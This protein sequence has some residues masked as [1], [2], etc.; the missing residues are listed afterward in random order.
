MRVS[1]ALVAISLVV[2]AL[3]VRSAAQTVTPVPF[4]TGDVLVTFKPGVN[5]NA[6][7]DAHRVVGATTLVEIPR[8]R[9]HRVRV[10]AG[11]E[12]AAIAR[13]RRNPNVLYAEPNF[14]RRISTPERPCSRL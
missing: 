13:Y 5:A 4:V 2:G 7:A 12:S 6:R 11:D 10:R 14:V 3:T 1:K 9:V 8:T